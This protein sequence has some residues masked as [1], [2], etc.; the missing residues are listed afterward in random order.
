MLVVARD[1]DQ[2]IKIGDDIW[3]TIVQIV[4]KREVRIGVQAP[5][6]VL[7][8]RE[9]LLPLSERFKPA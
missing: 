9:E 8:L 2:K 1:V 7:I 4:G 3:V 6:D 5:K